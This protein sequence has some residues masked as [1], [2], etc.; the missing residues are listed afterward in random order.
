[1]FV[2]RV[3]SLLIYTATLSYLAE[4]A[5]IEYSATTPKFPDLTGNFGVNQTTAWICIVYQLALRT[6]RNTNI[7][8][9][10]YFVYGIHIFCL[11]YF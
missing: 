2:L 5:D 9:T 8:L 7:H 4:F 11:Y 10:P 6:V 1:M 3:K